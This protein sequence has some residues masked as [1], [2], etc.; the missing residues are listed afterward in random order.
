MRWIISTL[1]CCALITA[2]LAQDT[3]ANEISLLSKLQKTL[4]SWFD[5]LSKSADQIADKED[6]RK[7]KDALSK[8]QN[9]LYEVETDGRNLIAMLQ[10][11]PLDKPKAEKAV[12]DTRTA[13]AALQ[14]RLHETG[15]LLRNQYRSGGADAEQMIADAIGQRGLWLGSVSGDIASGHVSADTIKKGQSILNLQRTAS[16]AVGEVIAKLPK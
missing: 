4:L 14:T 3:A 9:S 6:Q 8:L 12:G 5:D 11:T 2:A 10:M 15:L 7:L 13:L 1:C 16:V